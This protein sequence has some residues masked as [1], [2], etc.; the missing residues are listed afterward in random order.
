MRL[1]SVDI[2]GNAAATVM[3]P[4]SGIDNR[5]LV[6]GAVVSGTLSNKRDDS[7]TNQQTYS[8]G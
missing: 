5:A 2:P 8:F 6:D 7:P 1:F 3:L 4:A